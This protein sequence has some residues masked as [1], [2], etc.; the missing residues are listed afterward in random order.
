MP[1]LHVFFDP[2]RGLAVVAD[3]QRPASKFAGQVFR[4]L[5]DV[6][7]EL[8]GK[9]PSFTKELIDAD[10]SGFE[11]AA[12]IADLDGDGRPELYVAADDQDA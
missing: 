5:L 7:V 6:F 1:I 9:T 11:H 3:G 10:S 8:V 12:G 4:H 2:L